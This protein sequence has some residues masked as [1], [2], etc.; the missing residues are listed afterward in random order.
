MEDARLPSTRPRGPPEWRSV[1]LISYEDG[2]WPHTEDDVK[3]I[4]SHFVTSEEAAAKC[5][6]GI[7]LYCSNADV[8]RYDAR[9]LDAADNELCHPASDNITIIENVTPTNVLIKVKTAFYLKNPTFRFQLGPFIRDYCGAPES[10][11]VYKASL[12]LGRGVT[13]GLIDVP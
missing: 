6:D 12:S 2:R 10:N 9:C 7:R 11:R 3:L 13:L 5:P 1:L 8:D 4:E